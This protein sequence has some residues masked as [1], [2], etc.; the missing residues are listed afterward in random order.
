MVKRSWSQSDYDKWNGSPLGTFQ[1][2]D[3]FEVFAFEVFDF[4]LANYGRNGSALT[5]GI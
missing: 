4:F 5:A 2:L 1:N 3:E